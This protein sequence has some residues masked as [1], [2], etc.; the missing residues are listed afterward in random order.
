MRRRVHVWDNGGSTF[1]RYCVTIMRRTTQ[2]RRHEVY[3]MSDDPLSPQGFN[4]YSHTITSLDELPLMGK[5]INVQ[6]LPKDV[7]KAIEQRL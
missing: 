5:R 3:G 7:I 4:Q 2:G 6:D 1:D